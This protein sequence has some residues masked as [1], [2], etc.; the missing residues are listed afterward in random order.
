MLF[1]RKQL[2]D[3]VQLEV[4]VEQSSLSKVIFSLNYCRALENH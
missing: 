2:S 4:T 1:Y 3:P